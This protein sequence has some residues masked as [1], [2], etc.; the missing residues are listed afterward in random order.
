MSDETRAEFD[1]WWRA[2]GTH[3]RQRTHRMVAEY[4][5]QAAYAAGALAMRERAD[6]MAAAVAAGDGTLHGAIDHW[7][8]RA[9]KAEA[10]SARL[11]SGM[12]QLSGRD[13]F[14]ESFTAIHRGMNLRK[15][16]DAAIEYEGAAAVRAIEP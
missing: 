7:Q 9:I 6:S 15:A 12:I 16:I 11:D 2:D 14:G 3:R 10:D 13:E 4:A 5:W 1:R 8:G